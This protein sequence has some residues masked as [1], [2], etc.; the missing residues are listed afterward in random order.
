MK[1]KDFWGWRVSVALPHWIW[2]ASGI[3]LFVVGLASSGYTLYRSLRTES[4]AST[5]NGEDATHWRKLYLEENRQRTHFQQQYAITANR[6][7]ELEAGYSP[8]EDSR[9]LGTL[10][11]Y[12]Q[13]L[14][15][16]LLSSYRGS[17]LDLI[18]ATHFFKLSLLSHDDCGLRDMTIDFVFG[19]RK[20]SKRPLTSLS[21]WLIRT[22]FDSPEY[23]YKNLEE[24]SLEAL[25]LWRDVRESGL[26]SGLIKVGWIGVHIPNAN[27]TETVTRATIKIEKLQPRRVYRFHF[28][29]LEE[30]K[31]ADE[32][33]FHVIFRKP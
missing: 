5:S 13:D 18:E 33:I 31:N 30:A 14:E 22:P 23:P 11:V 16:E 25:S 7:K 27:F 4:P 20:Y 6:V 10:P 9:A 32:K 24:N 3:L 21:E 15:V 2:L 12:W 1:P 17:D 29:D 8:L 26:K 28:R 19:G